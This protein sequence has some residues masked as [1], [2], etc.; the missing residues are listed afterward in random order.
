MVNRPGP[1]RALGSRG[2]TI[3]ATTW[4]YFDALIRKVSAVT[5]ASYD[6]LIVE[7]TRTY[8]RQL[9]LYNGY[10]QGRIDPSTGRKF[11]P[12]YSPDSPYAYHVAGNAVDFGAGAGTRGTPVQKALHQYGPTFGIFF[13]VA[14]ELWHGRCDLN[15]VPNLD[16]ASGGLTPIDEDDMSE[17]QYNELKAA[18]DILGQ[19]NRANAAKLDELLNAVGIVGGQNRDTHTGVNAI[20]DTTRETLAAVNLLGDSV[21]SVQKSVDITGDQNR[22]IIAKVTPLGA[23]VAESQRVSTEALN[24]LGRILVKVWTITNNIATKVG[25]KRE[26]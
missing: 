11:N 3:N 14:S 16:P 21:R 19:Q 18:T 8:E 1:Q 13:E 22:E 15:R 24:N 12:A 9:Y 6:S 26:D 23:A 20:G 7:A 17:A 2:Q 5:G 10:V 4:P 25:S